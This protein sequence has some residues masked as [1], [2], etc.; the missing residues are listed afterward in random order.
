METKKL[1]IILLESSL[2]LVPKNII[3]EPEVIKT[4]KRYGIKPEEVILDKSLHYKAMYKLN[5]K[6]KRGRPDIVHTT[7][8]VL[9]GSFVGKKGLIETYIHTIQDKIYMIKPETR[10]PKHYERF[11]G[12]MAQL[13][14]DNKVPPYSSE[15]LIYKVSS[16]LNEFIKR[17]GKIILM[18]ERGKELSPEEIVTKALVTGRAIGIGAFPRGDFE[19]STLEKSSERYRIYGGK[20]LP[21]WSIAARIACAYEN[22][23]FH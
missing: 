9:E 15:P 4:A 3:N 5:R 17:Y 13:L 21:A 2:E 7:L 14:R 23:I 20:A 10:I 18:W 22:I 6:W 1:R 8:L 11:K 12:L 16:S 19:R